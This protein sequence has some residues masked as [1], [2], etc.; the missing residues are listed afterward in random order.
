MTDRDPLSSVLAHWQ[1]QPDAAPDFGSTVQARL[2][3]Q[4]DAR[5]ATWA[6]MLQFPA[7]LPLAAGFAIML[8]IGSALSMNRSETQSQMADA[9]ARSIDPVRMTASSHHPES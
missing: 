4:V 9:Y 1:P 7:T 5:P 3:A 2:Q 6:R 8:G